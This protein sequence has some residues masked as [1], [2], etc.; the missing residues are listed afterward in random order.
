MDDRAVLERVLCDYYHNAGT[1]YVVVFQAL[2]PLL[3][4]AIYPFCRLLH[5]YTTPVWRI[6]QDLP[7]F[8]VV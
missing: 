3:R 4:M 2:R 6:G 1:F 8:G 7:G 5:G